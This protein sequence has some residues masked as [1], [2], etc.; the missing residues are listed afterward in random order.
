MSRAKRS[1]CL[2]AGWGAWQQQ[3]CVPQPDKPPWEWLSLICSP[4]S[5]HAGLA[6][7]AVLLKLGWLCLPEASRTL[8][9]LLERSINHFKSAP[10]HSRV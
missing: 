5:P 4:C 10:F 2:A 6:A 9:A 7:D 3:C 1:T 8:G